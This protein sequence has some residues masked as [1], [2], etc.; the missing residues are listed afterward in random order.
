MNL[1]KILIGTLCLIWQ[2]QTCLAALSDDN[3]SYQIDSL[4]RNISI[5]DTTPGIAIGIIH[6]NNFI[7]K[8]H[9]GLS[10]LKSLKKIDEHTVF[11]LASVSKQ[12]TAAAI[13]LL[14]KQG[15]LSVKDN[16][17]KYLPDFPDYQHPVT[18]EHLIHHTC[19]I[20]SIDVLN[21]MGN[22]IEEQMSPKDSYDLICKQEQL[23]F[24]PGTEFLYSNSGYLLL[25]KIIEK[26]SGESYS[27]FLTNHIFIPL[28][29]NN[30]YIHDSPYKS[31]PNKSLAYQPN[32]PQKF[33][34]FDDGNDYLTGDSNI[35]TN[36]E[37]LLKWDRNFYNNK[38]G[39]WDF[40]KQ[41]F[42]QTSLPNGKENQYAYG[43]EVDDYKGIKT[44]S[45]QGGTIGYRSYYLQIPTH[46]L[47]IIVLS[48]CHTRVTKLSYA[49]LRIILKN[50]LKDETAIPTEEKKIV[51]LDT[52]LSNSYCSF[53]FDTDSWFA[54]KL[55]K[56]DSMLFFEDFYQNQIELHP[57][58]N[59][60]FFTAIPN[61]SFKIESDS[62]NNTKILTLN[63]GEDSMSMKQIP[64]PT[65]LNPQQSND[66]CGSYYC[67][68][69][70]ATYIV[71]KNTE[72]LFLQFPEMTAK[73]CGI[74]Q[75]TE[76]K[77]SIKDY[78]ITP[79]SAIKFLRDDSDN[80][81]K[82]IIKD[83]GRVRNLIFE[84][85]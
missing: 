76:L 22:R 13:V 26:V 8:K 7:F 52:K 62:I 40:S 5:N 44:I 30:T 15:K 25:A 71:E 56:K 21:L 6:Q 73:Y 33:T 3:L 10:D 50:E 54:M 57:S 20:R 48:N 68:A 63:Q 67:K 85:I 49:I 34:Q 12:F 74:P 45:H 70:D 83:I 60:D 69:I 59:T 11:N 23:N 9:Y 41:M 27:E 1:K 43:L 55:F 14:E 2:L 46:K 32:D 24:I 28:G 64:T 35:F 75:N 77:P 66:Y 31:I 37:D 39:N 61:L 29:M 51:K 17:N 36:L 42:K 53:Y 78:F 58:S 72:G 84:K 79:I 47:S 18:I 4:V 82:F 80:I 38:L 81:N 65:P 19:G 16:I